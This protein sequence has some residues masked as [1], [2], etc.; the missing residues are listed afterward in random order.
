TLAAE[1]RTSRKTVAPTWC[2][3]RRHPSPTLAQTVSVIGDRPIVQNLPGRRPF[4]H[5]DV[6]DSACYRS[7]LLG[8][9]ETRHVARNPARPRPALF[10]TGLPRDPASAAQRHHRS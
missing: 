7:I 6:V 9:K 10:R 1:T 3:Q 2:S 5:L 4:L 8:A